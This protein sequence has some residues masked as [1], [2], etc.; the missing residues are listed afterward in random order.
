MIDAR[1]VADA[2]RERFGENRLTRLLVRAMCQT[3]GVEIPKWARSS[4]PKVRTLETRK[5]YRR[6]YYHANVEKCRQWRRDYVARLKANHPEKYAEQLRRQRERRRLAKLSR[7]S[8]E[9]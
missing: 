8:T 6:R 9:K 1:K 7:R 5:E 2:I 4:G 3:A